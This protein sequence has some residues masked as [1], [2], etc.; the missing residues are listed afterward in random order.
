[1]GMFRTNDIV[2]DDNEKCE[3]HEKNQHVSRCHAHIE[4]KKSVGFV[5]FVDEGGTKISGKRTRIQR[6]GEKEPIDLGSDTKNFFPLHD[7]D[8]IELGKEVYL[9]FKYA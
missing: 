9:K 5:L 8:I 2:I 3:E 6:Q 7:G 4:Y 1:M